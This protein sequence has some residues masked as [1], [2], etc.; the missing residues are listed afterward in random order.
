[1]KVVVTGATGYIG[2]RLVPE[3][4]NARHEVTCIA[5]NP[6]K[7]DDRPWRDHVRVVEG[8]ITDVDTT[9]DALEGADVAYYLVH[10]MGGDRDFAEADAAAARAFRDAAGRARVGQIVYLGGL[11]DPD[12]KLSRHLASRHQVGRI[13][14]SGSVPTT[15]LRA[16]VII[17]SGSASFEMLRALVELL[18]VMITPRWV[19]K[20]LCQPIGIRD[21]LAYLVGVAGNPDA[22]GRVLEVGGPDVVTYRQ[23]MDRYA[24]VVGLKRRLIFP[25]QPLSPTLSRHWINLVTPL[26]IGLVRPLIGSLMNDVVV[27]DHAIDQIVPR[28]PLELEKTIRLAVGGMAGSDVPTRWTGASPTRTPEEPHPSDPGWSG[29]TL[30]SDVREVTSSAEPERLIQIASALGGR[31]GWLVG[32][33]LWD[34]RGLADKLIGGVGMRR[35]RR[36]PD[37]LGVGESLDFFRVEKVTPEHL[38]LR[39]EMKVPGQAWLEWRAERNGHGSVLTQ[40]AIFQPRGLGGRAYWYAIAPAHAFIFERLARR[41]AALAEGHEPDWPARQQRT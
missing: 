25:V 38:R 36:H 31:R 10:S 13:L 12:D 18:P 28:E 5:R 41:I 8:D 9:A 23:L 27:R 14:A 4:L 40:R 20:T 33:W 34:L 22:L 35:G 37:E 2:G 32:G 15:E 39:A 3:L 6:A 24:D 17:G 16:A 1:M 7:L 21:M 29:G 26:P 30:L 11:G 19:N